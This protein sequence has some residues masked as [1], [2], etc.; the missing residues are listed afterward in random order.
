MQSKTVDA[1][2]PLWIILA[3]VVSL[4]VLRQLMHQSMFFD[5]AIYASIARNLAEG[6]GSP[7]RLQFSETLFPVFSEHPPL[8]MWLEAIGFL[9]FGDTIAVEKCFSLMT[10]IVSGFILLKIWQRLHASDPELRLAGPMALAMALGAGRVSWGFTNGM[11]ENLLIVFTSL[12]AYCVIVAYDCAD[13]G[14]AMLRSILMIA[15]GIL[16]ALALMTKGLVGLFPLAT[17]GIWWLAFRRRSLIS[18]IAD[19]VVMTA[20]VV[21]FFAVLWQLDDAREAIQRYLSI[22]L[23]PSLTGQRGSGG[24]N[25]NAVRAFIRVNAYPAIV[26]LII[27]LCDRRWGSRAEVPRDVSR[28]R[29]RT[30]TFLALIG[31]SASLP[32]LV[33][34]RVA[35]FYF[36]P[37]LAYFASA[38]AIA[39]APIV[40]R[41]LQA[42][43]A[44][45]YRRLSLGLAVALALSVALVGF[46]IGRPGTDADT[47]ANAGRIADH[48]CPASGTCE[49]T[50]TACGASAEDWA[51]YSYLE[52][53]HKIS[54][55][56]MDA[57]TGNHV[58]VDDSC[59]GKVTGYSDTGLQ[60]SKYRLLQR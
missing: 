19:T 26:T 55:A 56:T 4:L 16:V 1:A 24:G 40:L 5:G 27:V 8:M 46:N 60:L 14:K 31:F 59:S 9:V 35:S 34:P 49:R 28:A 37:S 20:T 36:N 25:W 51:L 44:R 6:V 21:V 10:L 45:S 42:L 17:P 7:W 48:V 50:I 3:I 41:A 57:A 39:S 23:L 22:Q 32:L 53:R 52:R 18:V 47:I 12:A 54:L 2:K 11:L 38:F 33:S 43:N 30:A 29:R 13:R 15:A 58:V